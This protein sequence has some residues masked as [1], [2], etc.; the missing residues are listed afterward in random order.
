MNDDRA[1]HILRK[2]EHF[3][4]GYVILCL[5]QPGEYFISI[6]FSAPGCMTM[7]VRSLRF[8]RACT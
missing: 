3:L 6:T 4:A 7:M 5:F 1:W 8:A 2:G